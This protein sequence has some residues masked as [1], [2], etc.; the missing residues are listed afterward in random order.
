V[1]C[2]NLHLYRALA[3]VYDLSAHLEAPAN[4]CDHIRP[5]IVNLTLHC[6]DSTQQ[7]RLPDHIARRQSHQ[8]YVRAGPITLQDGPRLQRLPQCQAHL[9]LQEL[10]DSPGRPRRDHQPCKLDQSCAFVPT[11]TVC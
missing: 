5:P 3:T 9:R 8:V 4:H 1:S 7:S 2:T 6:R 11:A 10:Q